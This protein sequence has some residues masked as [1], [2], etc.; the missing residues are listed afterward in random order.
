MLA[1][2]GDSYPLPFP[3]A[4][5]GCRY[6]YLGRIG[7][8]HAARVLLKRAGDLALAPAYHNGLEIQALRTAGATVRFFNLDRRLEPDLDEIR[9]GLRDGAKLVLVIHFN[10]WP[11]PIEQIRALCRDHGA[12][13][14]EDCALAFLSGR[15]DAP[16]GSFGDASVFSL[17]KTLAVPNGG[18]LVFNGK[19][20]AEIAALQWRNPGAMSTLA[21]TTELAITWVQIGRASCRE[22]V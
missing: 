21:R 18:A 8:F 16:L 19:E 12:A 13:L 20:S 17:Y 15:G 1:G 9:R 4:L 10:G 11:Q 22:R 3:L 7:V 14:I 6:T 2:A 5:P